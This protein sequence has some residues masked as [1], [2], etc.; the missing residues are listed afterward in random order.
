MRDAKMQLK[1]QDT[2]GANSV[3]RTYGYINKSYIGSLAIPYSS[4]QPAPGEDMV[5]GAMLPPN[6][7]SFWA[8][9][10][11]VGRGLTSL[12]MSVYEDAVFSISASTVEELANE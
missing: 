3:S 11:A 2:T 5:A 6:Y 4:S 7:S 9:M 8:W 12:S 10:D 1:L